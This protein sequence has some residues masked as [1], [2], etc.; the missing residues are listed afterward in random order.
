MLV[1]YKVHSAPSPGWLSRY[2]QT[3]PRA[4]RPFGGERPVG[5][6]VSVPTALSLRRTLR[7][8]GVLPLPA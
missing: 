8:A 5:D 4:F 2:G 6:R 1:L 3:P 7:S